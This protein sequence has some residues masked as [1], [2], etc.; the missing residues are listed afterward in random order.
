MSVHYINKKAK[1]PFC[2][3]CQR[4]ILHYFLLSLRAPVTLL[5]APS[6]V[7]VHFLEQLWQEPIYYCKRRRNWLPPK[8]LQK[9]H[10][11]EQGAV[12]RR[13]SSHFQYRRKCHMNPQWTHQA[14]HIL[15]PNY[16]DQTRLIEW[17]IKKINVESALITLSCYYKIPKQDQKILLQ[18][19]NQNFTCNPSTLCPMQVWHISTSFTYDASF[20]K[21]Q[22]R[23]LIKVKR[24]LYF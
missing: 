16:P 22:A 7:Y 24:F 5:P 4:R 19:L 21:M 8:L 17:I 9:V 10:I 13:E 3:F 18:N 20:L 6:C 11:R 1:F 15:N 2:G 23:Y 14:L 12:Y